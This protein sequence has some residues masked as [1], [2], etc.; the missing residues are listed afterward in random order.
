MFTM[1]RALEDTLLQQFIYQKLEIAYAIYKPFPFLEGLRDNFFITETMY[2]ESMEA[3]RNQVPIPRV[4]Y[5]VLTH[6]EKNFSVS[7]LEMLFS[8]IN[9][10]EYPHLMTILKGFRS[11]TRLLEYL[12]VVIIPI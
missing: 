9:L 2:R 10:H 8:R 1:T 7:F 6:L 5:N 3:C 4:V 11:G 12:L